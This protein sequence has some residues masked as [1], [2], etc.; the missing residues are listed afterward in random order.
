VDAAAPEEIDAVDRAPPAVERDAVLEPE[1]GGVFAVADLDD[2]RAE[3]VRRRPAVEVHAEQAVRQKVSKITDVELLEE[4]RVPGDGAAVERQLEHVPAERQLYE[5]SG[6][7]LDA[8]VVVVERRGE[9]GELTRQGGEH[10]AR[11]QK[12]MVARV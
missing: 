10:A 6:L 11:R 5:V 2:L 3:E 1:L 9:Q 7:E 8:L 4:R 12:G